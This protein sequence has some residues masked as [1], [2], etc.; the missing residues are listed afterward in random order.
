MCSLVL[1]SWDGVLTSAPM[2]NPQAC[3][4]ARPSILPVW[5]SKPSET[6]AI[7]AS[8]YLGVHVEL[9]L[10]AECAYLRR[11]GGSLT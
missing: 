2:D 11:M 4:C 9:W 5:P 7:V 8:N 10:G 1:H 6:L 3:L